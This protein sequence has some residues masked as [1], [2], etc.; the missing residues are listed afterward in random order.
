MAREI[1]STGIMAETG[2]GIVAEAESPIVRR[3]NDEAL[4]LRALLAPFADCWVA[5]TH[6]WTRVVAADADHSECL[7]KARVERRPGEHVSFH[8]IAGA[9]T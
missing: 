3:A 7:R 1:E 2:A 4:K 8:W 5:L 6:D 9:P